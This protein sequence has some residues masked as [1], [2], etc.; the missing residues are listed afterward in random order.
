MEK[1]VKVSSNS[2]LN[3]RSGA[4]EAS[5]EVTCLLRRRI[6]HSVIHTCDPLCR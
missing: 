2:T 6:S 1:N 3:W 5:Y 4:A